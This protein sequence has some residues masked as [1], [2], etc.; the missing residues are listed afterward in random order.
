MHEIPPNIIPLSNDLQ[1][2]LIQ[3]LIPYIPLQIKNPLYNDPPSLLEPPS[4]PRKYSNALKKVFDEMKAVESAAVMVF[5]NTE[6]KPNSNCRRLSSEIQRIKISSMFT[7]INESAQKAFRFQYISRRGFYCA[8]CN[9]P[10]HQFIDIYSSSII[11]S[12]QFCKSLVENTLNFYIFKFNYFVRVSRLYALFLVTCDLKGRYSKDNYVAYDAK[13]F[14]QTEILTAIQKCQK[15]AAEPFGYQSCQEYCSHFN[16]AR[17][18]KLFDGDI[19]RMAGFGRYLKDLLK[20]KLEQYERDS[21]KDAL[22]IRGRLLEALI[23]RKIDMEHERILTG[24]AKKPE[25]SKDKAKDKG[26]EKPAK[27]VKDP[28][29]EKIKKGQEKGNETN[30]P[31]TINRLNKKHGSIIVVPVTYNSMDDPN[32][33]H[34]TSYKRSIF[35]RGFYR[36]YRLHKYLNYSDSFG[37]NW[38]VYGKCA[39]MNKEGVLQVLELLPPDDLQARELTY[40]VVGG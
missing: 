4:N 10:F 19:E 34:M 37:I 3:K 26:K 8:L 13:F 32:L 25:E 38:Y 27:A 36:T 30:V 6:D 14:E 16:P 12:N 9:Q 23:N 35:Y 11:S 29:E 40:D 39:M 18:S 33:T 2:N 24:E 15:N 7:K 1:G 22:N 17:Y 31:L 20:K 5:S 28:E 21:A